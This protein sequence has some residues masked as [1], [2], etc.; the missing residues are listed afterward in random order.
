MTKTQAKAMLKK[1]L[2]RV[3]SK[4]IRAWVTSE[5][6]YPIWVEIT[7]GWLTKNTYSGEEAE[8]RLST[9]IVCVAIGA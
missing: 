4:S 6:N 1:A 3:E 9:Y 5:Q 7:K 8:I 2:N